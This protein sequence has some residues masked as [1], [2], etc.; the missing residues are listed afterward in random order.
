M[1]RDFLVIQMPDSSDKRVMP[2]RLRRLD[3]SVLRRERLED[4]I[5]MILYDVV[6]NR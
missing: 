2:L 3:R 6:L 5:E 1:I 4:M